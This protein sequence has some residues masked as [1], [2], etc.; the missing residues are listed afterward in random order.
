MVIRICEIER[1]V[2]KG[3]FRTKTGEGWNNWAR[4]LFNSE[5][6]LTRVGGKQR[7][8]SSIIYGGFYLLI[9]AFLW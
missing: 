6:S 1:E 7:G 4:K 8:E 3:R 5:G 9:V 2:F